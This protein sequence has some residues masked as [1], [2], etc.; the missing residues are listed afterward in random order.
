M[1]FHHVPW[2]WR[3]IVMPVAGIDGLGTRA[4]AGQQGPDAAAW[5]AKYDNL[6]LKVTPTNV[7]G[8]YGVIKEEVARLT[9]S[10]DTFKFKHSDGTMPKLGENLVSP[11]AAQGFTNATRQLLA[12]CR[13]EVDNLDRVAHRLA[14]AARA[15]GKSEWRSRPH[16]T[17]ASFEYKPTPVPRS[18]PQAP[19]PPV[20]PTPAQPMPAVIPS[21]IFPRGM[22]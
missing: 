17:R 9:V 19:A 10:I 4:L 13:A 1:T 3:L 18:E 7:L 15:Y 16:S 22:R 21:S 5:A 2:G 8:I 6:G 11:Y 20:G 12:R 14:D